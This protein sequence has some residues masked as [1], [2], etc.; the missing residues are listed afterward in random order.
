MD[1]LFSIVTGLGLRF[2]LEGQPLGRLAPILLGLCEGAAV[3]HLSNANSVPSASDHYLAYALRVAV[4]LYFTANL[5]RTF[6]VLLWTLLGALASETM[7]PS[8]SRSPRER[9]RRSSRSVPA[10]RVRHYQPTLTP[11]SQGSR[12]TVVPIISSTPAVRPSRP[13]SPPSF[14]LEGESETNSNS[15]HPHYLP[16]AFDGRENSDSPPPKPVLLP[17]PP[18]TH[19]PD[20][21]AVRA[22]P[23]S[24]HRLSTIE[25]H[26]IEGQSSG[27]E[28]SRH[29]SLGFPGGHI[30]FTRTLASYAPSYAPS[31]TSVPPLPIPN[32]TIRYIQT[33]VNRASPAAELELDDAPS[34]AP[35]PVP[36]AG[37]TYLR[38]EYSSDGGDPL[39]TPQTRAARWELTDNDELMT[40]PGH[41]ARELSPL[42]LERNLFP[43][44]GSV[45]TSEHPTFQPPVFTAPAT[46]KSTTA[47]AP[48]TTT[49]T[50]TVAA[51]AG[52]SDARG[53]EAAPE[54]VEYPSTAARD[55]APDLDADHLATFPD[56]EPKSS[57]PTPDA[58]PTTYRFDD[59]RQQ[60]QQHEYDLG[61][62]F[63]QQQSAPDP[64]HN[65]HDD[66][67]QQHEFDLEEEAETE[68]D[69]ASVISS[70]PARAMYAR[71]EALRTEARA[72]EAEF[73]RL[74]GQLDEATYQA[75][76]RDVLFLK[77]E[78][79]EA[80][81]RATR[82]H[83]RAAR[84]FI[85]ARNVSKDPQTV[86]VHGLRKAE[87]IR[88]TEKALRDAF[89][90]GRPTVRVIVGKGLHS[91]D[92]IPVLKE[93]VMKAMAKY[94]IQCG[95]DPKNAGVLILT[96]P[97]PTP[98]YNGRKAHKGRVL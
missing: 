8:R 69:A 89:T 54:A 13:P 70:A 38:E 29:D 64:S 63:Q 87:A 81:K 60:D 36:N 41:G 52:S 84:R 32:S 80:E 62:G 90:E 44:F 66:D 78:M 97:M 21:R 11:A 3:H 24:E 91:A 43:A 22:G 25:E 2:F 39:Q 26:S 9:R 59:R 58:S 88:I 31:A 46:M 35:L 16:S 40:P 56:Q 12:S 50:A 33:S 48:M 15:P 1:V 30:G 28:G 82:L 4:D 7:N 74:R 86:D 18:A 77:E 20:G 55:A 37:T 73:D 92:G 6:V 76:V 94:G 5:Q 27:N 17:T 98:V 42:V 57:Y 34:V 85:M 83:E 19:V 47:T 96:L 65:Q 93:A 68:T 72:A 71:A 45:L 95:V 53:Q 79:R 61:T 14:F 67:Q 23:S 10:A 49:T 51:A 75:R